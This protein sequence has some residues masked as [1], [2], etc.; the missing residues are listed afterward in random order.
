MS[1]NF[2]ICPV[3]KYAESVNIAFK[4]LSQNEFETVLD[5]VK[6]IGVHI[7]LQTECEDS[8]DIYNLNLPSVA[9]DATQQYILKLLFDNNFP[10]FVN[11]I[12]EFL[13]QITDKIKVDTADD[14]DKGMHVHEEKAFRKT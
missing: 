2:I 10:C 8:K 1:K 7:Q 6:S 3:P 12:G 5:H 4:F 14:N 13:K 11:D 9:T